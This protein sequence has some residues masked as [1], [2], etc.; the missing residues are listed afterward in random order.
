[1]GTPVIL[2]ACRT[3][4]GKFCGSLGG[5][6]AHELGGFVIAE[7]VKRAGLQKEEICEGVLGNAWQANVGMNPARIAMVNAGLPVDIPAFSVNQRCG[8]GL[9]TVMILSDRIRLGSV[10]AGVAGGMESASNVPYFLEGAR[11]GFRM[12]EQKVVDGLHKDGFLCPFTGMLMGE[13]GDVLAKEFS[14]SRREQDEYAAESHRKAL[15]AAASGKFRAEIVPVVLREKKDER[16]FDRDEIPREDTS[17]EKLASLPPVFGK[18]GTITAGNSSGLC[19]A[20]SALVVAD[21]D[22]AEANGY[23]PLA[24]IRGYSSV[25][26]APLYMGLGPVFAVPKALAAAGLSFGDIDLIELNEAFAAQVLAVHSKMPFDM[27]RCN[28]FG[29]AIALGHP[30]GATGAKIL[31]TLVHGLES[32]DKQF[33]LVTLCVGG[34]QGVAMVI[35]RAG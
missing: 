35:E 21:L 2:S 28:I 4:G 20:A 27:E 19:D 16:L 23:R 22:W 18:D 30:S 25:A 13:T 3:A 9:Q 8:T 15:A 14:I 1:M 5:F 10:T 17:V 11:R 7:A 24:K 31:T 26:L 29:G 33:G 34:G 32:E 6:S 12:G